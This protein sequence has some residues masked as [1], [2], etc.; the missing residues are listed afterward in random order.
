MSLNNVRIP[1]KI[2]IAF[3]SVCLVILASGLANI[4]TFSKLDAANSRFETLEAFALEVD[5]YSE[6]LPQQRQLVLTFMLTGERALLTEV[7]TLERERQSMRGRIGG[8]NAIATG[9]LQALFAAD[10]AL[11]TQ[12]LEPQIRL[13]RKADTVNEARAIEITTLPERLLRARQQAVKDLQSAIDGALGTARGEQMAA[14]ATLET[15][16]YA[17]VVIAVVLA[18]ALGL[19]LSRAIATPITGMNAFMRRLSA[20]DLSDSAIPGSGRRDEIGN[21]AEAVAVFRDGLIRARDLAEE[22]SRHSAEREREQQE[23]QRLVQSFEGTVVGVLDGLSRA[24]HL[25]RETADRMTEGAGHTIAT[26][27]AARTAATGASQDVNTVAASSE[28]LST[29]IQEIARRVAEATTV[30]SR[31]VAEADAG[32]REIAQLDES[33]ARIGEVV[34][35]INDIASQTNLLALNATI[36]AARAGDAGKGFAVVANEVKGLATQTARATEDVGRQIAAI[37]DATRKAVSAIDRVSGI[38]REIDEISSNIAAAVEEQGAATAEIARGAEHTATAT[39]SVVEVMDDLRNAAE[40]SGRVAKDIA[41]SSQQISNQSTKL[42][43]EVREFLTSVS[44]A[45]AHDGGAAPQL[46]EFGDAH[47]FG[48]PAIDEEH[49]HLME[50]TNDLYRAIKSGTDQSV[51]D[52]CFTH[53]KSYSEDHFAK[54]DAYMTRTGYPAAEEHRRHHAQ[55]IE[56]LERLYASYR[57]GDRT[58]GMDLLALLGNWWRNHM[59]DDDARLAKFVRSRG[60]AKAA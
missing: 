56:R 8:G 57:G 60:G 45:H 38:I 9:P 24:D 22:Q 3:A 27:D 43:Q 53:L 13:M 2:A 34:G 1:V 42:K 40:D 25:L 39:Q 23:L 29:S 16:T 19:I 35:L 52:R 58:A 28:E 46:V 6:I 55:F 21:M 32:S 49:R 41:A 47:V 44:S 31:G 5:A 18:I 48:V 7:D 37:Q 51:L 11:R 26:A 59:E 15:V 50:V 17:S 54:E 30:A 4:I 12:V 14:D 33:V 20:G 10:D 36:E